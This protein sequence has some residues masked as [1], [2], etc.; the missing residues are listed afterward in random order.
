MFGEC[1]H[2]R[3]HFSAVGTY[4][5]TLCFDVFVDKHSEEGF[6]EGFR[7]EVVIHVEME[8]CLFEFGDSVEGVDAEFV[9]K[10]VAFTEQVPPL[11]EHFEA[12]GLDGDGF[13][14]GG[15]EAFV[16][17]VKHLVVFHGLDD[18]LEV[19]GTGGHFFEH[20]LVFDG[21]AVGEAVVDGEGLQHPVLGGVVVEH[22]GVVDEVLVTVGGVALN[23]DSEHVFYSL[24]HP[25]E[26]GSGER[27]SVV[28]V[29]VDP[30]MLD[31]LEVAFFEAQKGVDEPD[32]LSEGVGVSH[33]FFA[34]VKKTRECFMF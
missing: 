1:S 16:G 33:V 18:G 20:E 26:G 15:V 24:S 14:V 12:V 22:L 21:E 7:V 19:F 32:E 25:V 6:E 31:L 23:D 34:K 8:L 10:G 17:H 3:D 13:C 27:F 29:F 28:K 9:V 5:D 2:Q 11:S 4:D 30:P